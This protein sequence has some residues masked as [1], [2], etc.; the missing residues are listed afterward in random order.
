MAEIT[1][2]RYLFERLRQLGVKTIFGVPGG[3]WGILRGLDLDALLF[4]LDSA[5]EP[6]K[7][8]DTLTLQPNRLRTCSP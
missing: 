2:G 4:D 8:N 3:V 6:N 7:D 1:V 5:I